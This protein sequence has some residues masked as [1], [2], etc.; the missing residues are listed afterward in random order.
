[1]TARAGPVNGV[2]PTW[3]GELPPPVYG[4]LYPNTCRIKVLTSGATSGTFGA[5]IAA[6]TYAAPTA[7]PLLQ[8]QWDGPTLVKAFWLSA[9]SDADSDLAGLFLRIKDERQRNLI[10]CPGVGDAASMQSALDLVGFN[11]NW[12][13]FERVVLRGGVNWTF[14]LFNTTA[15]PVT[16]I[17]YMYVEKLLPADAQGL[18][19]ADGRSV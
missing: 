1:M 10:T 2:H 14:Q 18:M 16:P 13:P 19:R 6:G 15:G 7:G 11:R 12:Y 9:L 8:W 5:A 4:N 3:W 17:L